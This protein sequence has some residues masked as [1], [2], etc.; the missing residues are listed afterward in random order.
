MTERVHFSFPVKAVEEV[1]ML[2]ETK[3]I[4]AEKQDISLHFTPFEI[5]TIKIYY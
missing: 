5:K 1:N 2:E 4:I 3:R